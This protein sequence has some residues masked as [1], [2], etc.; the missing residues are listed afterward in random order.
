MGRVFLR[1]SNS[2]HSEELEAFCVSIA[3]SVQRLDSITYVFDVSTQD[4]LNLQMM[5]AGFQAD[6]GLSLIVVE[7]FNHTVLMLK[8]LEYAT[9]YG[10]GRYLSLHELLLRM[11]LDQDTQL[12]DDLDAHLKT[13]S[14]ELLDTARM[15]LR[16]D[17]NAVLA[18]EALYLHRNTF[19]YRMSKFIEKSRLDIREPQLA[20]LFSL[21]QTYTSQ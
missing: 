17:G 21:W 14:A 5:L 13:V 7:G 4:R 6:M 18:A 10:V 19:N 20:D 11:I 2:T 15:Y 9:R 16:A 12:M 3:E 8:A 1:A